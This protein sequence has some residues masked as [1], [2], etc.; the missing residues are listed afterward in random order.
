LTIDDTG[1]LENE[2]ITFVPLLNDTLFNSL[3]WNPDGNVLAAGTEQGVK[4][5]PYNCNHHV[6]QPVDNGFYNELS[7][8]QPIKTV[9]FI[10]NGTRII[11]G[12]Q[13]S[14][15][16]EFLAKPHGQISNGTLNFYRNFACIVPTV[17]TQNVTMNLNKF[18]LDIPATGSFIINPGVT[19]T[20]K[21]A[22]IKNLS[23]KRHA[24]N[25]LKMVNEVAGFI[26]KDST[27]TLVLDGS[28]L[29]LS[30]DIDFVA[31]GNIRIK[32]KDSIVYNSILRVPNEGQTTIISP[33]GYS[34]VADQVSASMVFIGQSNNNVDQSK[35]IVSSFIN[36][37]IIRSE[38][39]LAASLVQAF[40]EGQQQKNLF[41][42][43]SNGSRSPLTI[44][45]SES[46]AN[47][48]R[49]Q[50]KDYMELLGSG[51][52]NVT[53]NGHVHIEGPT[54]VQ[55]VS[56]SSLVENTVIRVENGAHLVIKS[57]SSLTCTGQMS[58]V[59]GVNGIIIVE[60][61]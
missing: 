4:L 61:D 37:Q 49:Y 8:E 10:G 6:Y 53:I 30:K 40:S 59:A 20:I 55:D 58:L 18:T 50:L 24:L 12:G 41:E 51:P 39:A 36:Q 42:R 5:I 52:G 16:A 9:K 60:D 45:G 3:E 43:S 46:S 17:I 11:V 15:V 54:T 33:E 23:T 26:F 56:Q 32:T 44:V 28:D 2:P 14:A 29:N 25:S 47:P 38:T 13:Y 22:N 19:L 7:S 34:F 48:L 57:G 1:I 27:S 35:S 31:A 21:N